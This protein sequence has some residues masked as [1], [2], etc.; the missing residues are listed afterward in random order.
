MWSLIIT[1]FRPLQGQKKFHQ[2]SMSHRCCAYKA[3]VSAQGIFISDFHPHPQ[4]YACALMCASTQA[5]AKEGSQQPRVHAA[6]QGG[7]V[8]YKDGAQ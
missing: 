6:V 2:T 5:A 1:I 8:I 7:F 3:I 4:I